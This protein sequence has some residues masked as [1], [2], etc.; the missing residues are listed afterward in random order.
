MALM[1][2]KSLVMDAI[3]QTES[4][5]KCGDSDSKLSFPEALEYSVLPAMILEQ[6]ITQTW[7]HYESGR[8]D[9]HTIFVYDNECSPLESLALRPGFHIFIQNFF[10]LS[11]ALYRSQALIRAV[12]IFAALSC[13]KMQ[14][15]LQ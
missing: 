2:V 9:Q 13:L 7:A 15:D 11:H 12:L 10:Q 1:A 14:V 4:A 8:R 5:S 3:Q 6:R